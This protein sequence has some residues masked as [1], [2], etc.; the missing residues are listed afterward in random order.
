[1]ARRTLSM[2]MLIARCI[3]VLDFSACLVLPGQIV[4]DRHH[5]RRIV[6]SVCSFSSGVAHQRM[7]HRARKPDRG[8]DALQGQRHDHYPQHDDPG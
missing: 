6:A 4:L 3:L 7:R 5:H 8:G 1:M 2:F